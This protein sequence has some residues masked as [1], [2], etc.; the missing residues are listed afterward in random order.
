MPAVFFSC[1]RYP[2]T[3]T[4]RE[5]ESLVTPVLPPSRSISLSLPPLSF[6][7]EWSVERFEPRVFPA[8]HCCVCLSLEGTARA[9]V[10]V[11]RC[12]H[13]FLP[14][15]PCR[16]SPV[17]Y[18]RSHIHLISPH[19]V[20]LCTIPFRLRIPQNALDALQDALADVRTQWD[21]DTTPKRF[22]HYT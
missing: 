20:T 18:P 19:G 13:L 15:I 3:H 1:E 7:V 11:C 8:Q 22:V 4:Q 6:S 12:L 14:L 5:R 9:A 10:V 17:V 21:L 16:L 2:D